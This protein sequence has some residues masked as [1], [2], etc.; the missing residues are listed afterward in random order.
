MLREGWSYSTDPAPRSWRFPSTH[1]ENPAAL[2]F[3]TRTPEPS[4]DPHL[5]PLIST[6]L[7]IYEKRTTDGRPEGESEDAALVKTLR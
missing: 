3:A 1:T 2:K 5:P 6:G 4:T 7:F